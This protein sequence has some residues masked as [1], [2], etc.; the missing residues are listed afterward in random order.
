MISQ[1]IRFGEEN[2]IKEKLVNTNESDYESLDD[3]FEKKINHKDNN[4]N[5]LNKL[6]YEKKKNSKNYNNEFGQKI[7]EI[8]ND[9]QRKKIIQFL[10]NMAK[11]NKPYLI[12]NFDS[13]MNKKEEE[14]NNIEELDFNIDL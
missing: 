3:S 1:T 6:F 2:N 13:I 11:I 8:M 5:I 12:D 9:D 14:I 7:F 10:Y 4:D